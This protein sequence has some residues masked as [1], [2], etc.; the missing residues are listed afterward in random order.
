MHPGQLAVSPQAVRELVDGQFPGWHGLAIR[1][2]NA[3]GTVNAIFSM[4]RRTLQRIQADGS[5]ALA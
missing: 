3:P 1:A 2:V 5:P 4:G